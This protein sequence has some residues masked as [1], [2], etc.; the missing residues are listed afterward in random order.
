MHGKVKQSN[1]FM[2]NKKVKEIEVVKKR[3]TKNSMSFRKNKGMD[4]Y[5]I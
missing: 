1:D 3:S 2:K 5:I 4:I